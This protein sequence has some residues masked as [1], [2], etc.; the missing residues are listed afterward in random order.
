MNFASSS[1]VQTFP[2]GSRTTTRSES[3][4]AASIFSAS[5]RIPPLG[6]FTSTIFNGRKCSMRDAYSAHNFA[7]W[8][9]FVFP[10]HR[11]RSFILLMAAPYLEAARY[12]ACASRRACIRSRSSLESVFFPLF[13]ESFPADAEDLRGLDLLPMHLPQHFRNVVTFDI[14]QRR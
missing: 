9:F 3:P 6:S 11:T 14:F 13:E 10:T 12:R 4:S 8:E 7:I 5:A 1:D 2:F